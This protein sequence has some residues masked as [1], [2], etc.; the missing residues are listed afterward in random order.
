[1]RRSLLTTTMAVTLASL[2][3]APAAAA[4]T[5]RG[6]AATTS[7]PLHVEAANVPVDLGRLSL[8][9]STDSERVELAPWSTVGL[10]LLDV[11]GTRFGEVSVRSDGETTSDGLSLSRATDVGT[12]GATVGDVLAVADDVVGSATAALTTLQTDAT[13]LQNLGLRVTVSDVVSGVDD[14]GASATHTLTLAGID[15]D[16]ANVLGS[17]L[18]QLPLDDL[19]A[20]AEQLGV[21][22]PV[23]IDAASDIAGATQALLVAVADAA[24]DAA[25]VD[26]AVTDLLAADGGTFE[27][28]SG[29]Q[30][31]VEALTIL[32]AVGA[33]QAIFDSADFPSACTLDLTGVVVLTDNLLTGVEDCLQT[34][35]DDHLGTL[36][37]AVTAVEDA[38]TAY[39]DAVATALAAAGDLGDGASLGTLLDDIAQLVADLLAVDLLEVGDIEVS[40]QVRA[41]GGQL[42]A[43][44]ASHTCRT[45]AVTALAQEPVE[46][47][48]C[49][50]GSALDPAL[51]AVNDTIGAILDT[52]GGVDA[53][54]GVELTLF[55]VQEDAVTET[56]DGFVRAT[57]V[58]EVLRL[59]I[60]D[61][62]VSACGVLDGVACSLGVDLDA[63]V[64]DAIATVD[65][66]LDTAQTTASAA[67]ATAAPLLTAVASTADVAGQAG[68]QTVVDDALAL[69]ATVIDTLDL[70]TLTQPQALV[71]PGATIVV[72]PELEAEHQV[73]TTAG[74]PDPTNPAPD[75]DDPTLPNTGGG[76][77]ALALLALG[78]SAMLR[79]RRESD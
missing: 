51:T 78:A 28:L 29:F 1:M 67:L 75:P 6:T 44:S 35:I 61:V 9:A 68:A 4:T 69:I 5:T 42:D 18:G 12:V 37:T 36:S 23:S 50:G 38:V 55:G 63:T 19:V 66:V 17:V 46:V 71:L 76:A 15:L 43:S 26:A 73:I 30:D 62:T 22:V 8:M 40:Q 21:E 70:G 56:S 53:G 16:L 2:L 13:V 48:D 60:P 33:L 52:V 24:T 77:A 31:A 72:D 32:D 79:R 45:T 7:V 41:I 11:A 34:A 39:A 74:S 64:A 20:L 14:T 54:D 57:S 10:T 25:A 49:A 65:G 58:L 3:A 27:T 47:V 59:T